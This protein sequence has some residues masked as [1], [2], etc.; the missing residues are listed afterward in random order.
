MRS[1]RETNAIVASLFP[2]NVRSRLFVN[3]ESGSPDSEVKVVN[4]DLDDDLQS[5]P[6]ADLL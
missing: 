5:D 1:A 2:E 4:H 6:I 3:G